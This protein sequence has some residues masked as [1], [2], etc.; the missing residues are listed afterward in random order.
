MSTRVLLL[1]QYHKECFH[2]VKSWY[3]FFESLIAIPWKIR[4]SFK[5]FKHKNITMKEKKHNNTKHRQ[6]INIVSEQCVRDGKNKVIQIHVPQP[7]INRVNYFFSV[8]LFSYFYFFYPPLDL[9]VFRKICIISV[10]LMT[11]L[12]KKISTKFR[13]KRRL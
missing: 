1:S 12:W 13:R 10:T 7:A 6:T 5:W 11:W 9:T 3:R 8:P 4:A 2:R